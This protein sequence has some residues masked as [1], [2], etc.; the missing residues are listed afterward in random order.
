MLDPN[1]F[2]GLDIN[3][4]PLFFSAATTSRPNINFWLRFLASSSHSLIEVPSGSPLNPMLPLSSPIL[5]SSQS[6]GLGEVH[7]SVSH[8]FIGNI[9]NV[10]HF[11]SAKLVL[12]PGSFL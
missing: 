9:W 1:F 2:P 12:I 4:S 8:L 7:L 3:H 11:D 5:S 10:D 6:C